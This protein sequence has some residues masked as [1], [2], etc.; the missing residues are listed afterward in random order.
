MVYPMNKNR[1]LGLLF[2]FFIFLF[3]FSGSVF[4]T[5]FDLV[6][7]TGVLQRGQNITFTININTEG[8]AVTSVQSGLTFDSTVLTYVSTTA[9]AAMSA[10]VA[11]TTTYGAGKVLLTGT[12]N[13]GYSGTGVFATV[14]F[15]ITDTSS[16]E[17]E[18]CSLW[19]PDTSPTPTVGPTPT[20]G[21]S[22]GTSCTANSQCPSD[23]P[24]YIVSG[25]TSG[26]CRR[27]ACPEINSCV[28]PVPSALPVTGST[29]SGNTAVMVAVGF[30]AAAGGI[31]YL[32]QKQKYTFENSPKKHVEHI[33]KQHHHKHEKSS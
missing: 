30:I 16:G 11:D 9:G 31:L 15:T 10:V 3:L 17:T 12:N 8:T 19:I 32:S 25:Q 14:V 2:S 27:T 5:T 4:A 1:Y 18:I 20:T 33:P 13:P 7:P 6:P 26:Y 22:C 21:P 24:C 29:D 23:M 28:C